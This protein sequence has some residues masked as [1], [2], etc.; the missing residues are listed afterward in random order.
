[1]RWFGGVVRFLLAAVVFFVVSGFVLSWLFDDY[2][3]FRLGQEKVVADV[4]AVRGE[5]GSWDVSVSTPG[6]GPRRFVLRGDQWQLDVRVVKWKPLVWL[7]GVDSVA[8]LDRLSGRYMSVEDQRSH[9][10]TVFDLRGG[11]KM[12][13]ASRLLDVAVEWTP[14]V[15]VVFGA[16]VFDRLTDGGE[17]QVVIGAG[18]PV[19]RRRVFPEG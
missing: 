7:L 16:S 4:L 1:M 9:L 3:T 12:D 18:G 15:D 19:V 11:G 6:A 14:W 17:W 5:D 2:V 10:P 13:V 8:E